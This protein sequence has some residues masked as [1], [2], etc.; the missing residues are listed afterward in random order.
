M[1]QAV[2]Q[3]EE[4]KSFVVTKELSWGWS[5]YKDSLPDSRGLLLRGPALGLGQHGEEL[6]EGTGQ[7]ENDEC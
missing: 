1:Y 3:E 7:S 2:E 4:T 6:P 5:G